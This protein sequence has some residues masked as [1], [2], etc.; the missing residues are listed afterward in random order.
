MFC[1]RFTRGAV[2][3]FTLAMAGAITAGP[4]AGQQSESAP[5]QPAYLIEFH[6]ADG[7]LFA[8]IGGPE[9]RGFLV[10]ALPRPPKYL[11]DSSG[12][13]IISK[14][15]IQAERSGELWKLKVA[16]G[17]GEFYDAGERVIATYTL[18]TNER[19]DVGEAGQFGLSPFRI[20][21]VKV[22]GQDA[23]KPRIA[24]KTKSISL[25]NLEANT[26]PEPYR[27]LLKNNSDK[28]V[29]AIQY[30]TYKNQQFLHLKWRAEP[31]SLPL[32]K[33]GETY[34]LRVLSEDRTCADSD[35]YRPAQSNKIEIATIVFADGSYEG[36]HG[37]A[38]LVLG[39]ALGTA[40]RLDRV[41]ATLNNL[42]AH[43]TPAP[44]LLIYHL[45][46]LAVVMDEVAEP[47][48]VEALQRKLPPLGN[49]SGDA[50][51][52][53]V[54]HGQHEIKTSLLRD[55]AE[56]ETMSKTQNLEAVRERCARTITKYKTWLA[57]AEAVS[58][59]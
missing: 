19:A 26:L 25:E 24:L 10:D 57:R 32:I 7:C 2:V 33:A 59:H 54:R 51:T 22:L 58:S 23:G 47:S 5:T 55:A 1:H 17:V 16:I 13:P 44:E 43:E 29:L 21:V 53:F 42:G 40:Q 18:R 49:E 9:N 3:W 8:P 4:V 15:A 36:D 11:P 20:G 52:N 46:S 48:M 34:Q 30:N 35:G 31:Q 6:K 28:H 50:L 45:R 39:N 41:V 27:L 38:A 56:L 12:Q 14:I 37:L